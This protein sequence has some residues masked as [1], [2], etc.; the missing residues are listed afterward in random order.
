MVGTAPQSEEGIEDHTFQ[1]LIAEQVPVLILYAVR[2]LP[3]DPKAAL[4]AI[5]VQLI[6]IA[7]AIA[8]VYL[9]L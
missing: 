1:L 9:L 2:W 8:P 3:R 5:G 4:V 7:G 6:A